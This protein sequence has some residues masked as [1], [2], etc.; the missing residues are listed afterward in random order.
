M[1]TSQGWIKLHR[2]LLNHPLWEFSTAEQKVMLVTLLMLANHAEN[3]WHWNGHAYRCKPGQLIT[4]LNSLA[5]KCGN[6]VT[7]RKVQTALRFFEN[8]GFLVK[9]TSRHNTLI[10]ICN[11]DTYQNVPDTHVTGTKQHVDNQR[12]TDVTPMPPNKKTRRKNKKNT[13]NSC[14]SFYLDPENEDLEGYTADELND[15]DLA[16]KLASEVSY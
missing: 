5:N 7:R 10:T 16:A 11:W 15:L 13:Q 12:T 1:N 4:S 3:T 2:R 14:L 8:C 9:R 6:G